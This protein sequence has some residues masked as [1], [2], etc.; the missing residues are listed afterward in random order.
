MYNHAVLKQCP[1]CASQTESGT[2]SSKSSNLAGKTADERNSELTRLLE[3]SIQASDRTTFAVRAMVSYTVI[4]VITLL[5]TAVFAG[6]TV[7]GGGGPFSAFFGFIGA[8]V[9]VIGTIYALVTLIREWAL[10]KVPRS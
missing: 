3:K 5:V 10:S 2:T 4:T 8:L 1:G 7:L 6:F 9:L